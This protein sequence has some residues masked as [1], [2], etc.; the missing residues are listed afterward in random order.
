MDSWENAII[1]ELR[2]GNPTDAQVL[3]L[4]EIGRNLGA[5]AAAM[6]E[7]VRLEQERSD[8]GKART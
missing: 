2:D 8:G 4:L 3:A 7:Y 5:L 6:R 1:K